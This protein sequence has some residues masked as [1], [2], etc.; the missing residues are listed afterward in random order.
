M[1]EAAMVLRIA[2]YLLTALALTG[3]HHMDASSGALVG[4]GIGA[5]TGA[6]IGHQSGNR[7]KGA[8]IGAAAGA[9]GG[10]LLGDAQASR[11]ERDAAFAQ[12]S[13]AQNVARQQAVTNHDI[14]VMTQSGLTEDVIINSIRTRGGNFDVS[15]NGLVWLQNSGV[16]P[17]VIREMQNAGTVPAQA[18]APVF[19]QPDPDVI[20]VPPPPPQL[21]IGRPIRRG[22]WCPS[23]RRGLHIHGRF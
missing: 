14:V 1:D 17:N 5:G 10:A 11:R 23:R 8:L 6:I 16:S 2:C 3:C 12:A 4:S 9:I 20:V 7:G 21:V 13:H 18:A 15:P 19:V 22:R